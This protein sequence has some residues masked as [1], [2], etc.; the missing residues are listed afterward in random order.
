M[1]LAHEDESE[2]PHPYWYARIIGI[3]H[4]MVRHT[5]PESRSTM[6]QRVE[7][8]W[9]RWLGR[10]LSSPSGWA[11]KRLPR[12]GFLDRDD[13]SAFGFLDPALVIRG[14]HLI[15]AFSYGTSQQI[16]ANSPARHPLDDIEEWNY[17]YINM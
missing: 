17:F 9:V 8:L 5:G 10:D 16:P 3:F 7:F 6:P 2:N 1:V 11:A 14:V 4:V 12:I 13:S 15:P